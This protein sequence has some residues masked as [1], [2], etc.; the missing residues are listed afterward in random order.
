MWEILSI[1]EIR[2]IEAFFVSDIKGCSDIFE[3]FMHYTSD[4]LS[5]GWVCFAEHS[6]SNIASRSSALK[7]VVPQIFSLHNRGSIE[8]L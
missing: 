3:L 5:A 2:L 7:I 4:L 8:F 6:T 1:A